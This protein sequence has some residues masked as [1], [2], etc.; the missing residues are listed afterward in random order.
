MAGVVA[1]RLRLS[2]IPSLPDSDPINA[3]MTNSSQPEP[4]A[5]PS[6]RPTEAAANPTPDAPLIYQSQELLAGRREIWIEHGRDMYRLRLT[7]QHKLI[8]T[9]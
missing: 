3:T 1:R 5:T 4:Q 6:D 2:S 7:Q 8:L 9:K